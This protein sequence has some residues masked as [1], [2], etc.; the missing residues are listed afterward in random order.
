MLSK[1]L[2]F[3]C[4]IAVVLFSFFW[5]TCFAAADNED[6]NIRKVVDEAIRPVMAEFDIPGMAVAVTVN[7]KSIFFNYG[8]ASRENNT[9][10]SETTIFEIGSISKTFTATLASYAQELGKLSMNDHPSKYVPLLR[11]S[12]IDKATLLHLGTYTA[13]GLPLQFPDEISKS[14]MLEYFQHWKPD[15]PVGAQRQY[16]NPSIGLLGHVAAIALKTD[17]ADAIEQQ[18]LP[19]LSMQHSYIRIPEKEMGSYAWGY[20][21][22]NKPVRL[23]PGVLD[24]EAYGIKSTAV[25]MIKFVQANIDPSMLEPSLKRAIEHTHLAFFRVAE[26]SQGLVWEQYSYPTTLDRLLAGNSTK[27][28]FEA[29]TVKQITPQRAPPN[30]ILFNKTGSTGGFGS[31]MVF[32]PS[33]K[34]GVVMLANR[35]LPIPARIKAAHTI[36]EKLALTAK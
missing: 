2:K 8:V 29:N 3:N 35:S 1:L 31:Y 32:V 5:I 15:V 27:M 36:L 12:A 14:Q 26:M 6:A 22:S 9:P 10:V 19:K 16:S 11:G 25:D 28:I 33:K 13:G 17:F 18:L 20:N 23:N 24:D 30:L 7:G 21:K 4:R 34:I